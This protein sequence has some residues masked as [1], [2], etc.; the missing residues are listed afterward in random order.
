M[1]GSIVV[2]CGH[3]GLPGW[4]ES[5]VGLVHELL[6]EARV[7]GGVI[8]GDSLIVVVSSR[9]LVHLGAVLEELVQD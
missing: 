6:V 3:D 5:K 9:T 1:C 4:I 8:V 2:R 7:N